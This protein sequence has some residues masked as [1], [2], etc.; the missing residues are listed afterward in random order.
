MTGSITGRRRSRAALAAALAFATVGATSAAWAQ[1]PPPAADTRAASIAAAEAAKSL[2]VKPYEAGRG[3][4]LIKKLEEAFLTGNLHWHPFFQ[5]AYSG[6][7]FTLGAGYARHVS[8]Y[9]KIDVRGSYTPKGYNALEA[10]FMAPRL[11]DRRGE[12]V[13]ARAAGAAPPRWG[14]TASAP[15]T[16]PATIASTTASSSPTRRL[17]SSSGRRAA[18]W[19]LAPGLELRALAHGTGRAAP[20]IGRRGLHAR[21]AA[22]AGRPARSTSHAARERRASTGGLAGLHAPRRLLRRHVSRL[23]SEP[24]DRYGF[25]QTDYE[26]IQHVPLGAT[27]GCCRSTA[28]RTTTDL[29]DDQQIPYFMHARAWRR[30]AACAGSRAG[31]SATGTACCCRPSCASSSARSST[32]RSSTTPARSPAADPISTSTD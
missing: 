7:G 4:V 6:G 15:G 10:E 9:N 12:P 19:C 8:S 32:W 2:T 16:P 11:F 24:D 29:K 5:N 30:I 31:A 3:E 13:G 1:A 28:A 21:H 23:H 26:A 17:T 27:S 20:A 25:R 22:R 14:S 18:S